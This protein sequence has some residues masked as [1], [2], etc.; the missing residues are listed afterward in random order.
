MPPAGSAGAEPLPPAGPHDPTLGPPPEASDPHATQ[1]TSSGGAPRP[2]VAAPST[3]AG[4]PRRFGDYELLAEVARGGMG[5]VYRARHLVTDRTVA[6]KMILAGDLATAADVERFRREAKAAAALEHPGIVP[7]YDVGEAEG[8]HYFTMPFVAGGSLQDRLAD[9]PLPP[10]L[11]ARLVR[12]LAEAVQYAHDKGIVHR[13][14]KPRNVLLQP[15]GTAPEGNSSA[16]TPRPGS[17]KSGHGGESGVAARLTDFGLARA[18]AGDG[19]TATGELLGTPAYMAPEQAA[20]DTRRIG[21]CSDVYGLG[22]VLYALLTG[23]PPFQAATP[24][25]TLRQVRDEEP[26]PPRRLNPAVPA[27]LATVCLKCLH[28]EPGRRYSSAAALADDLGRFVDGRPVLARPV[29]RLERGRRW[30]RRNPA[31]AGL[32][33]AVA[34]SLVGGAAAATAFAVRANA[35]A[36][37][38]D[39]E[40][41]E[42]RKARDGARRETAEARRQKEAAD[43]ATYVAQIGRAVADLE[44]GSTEGASAALDAT[45][46]DLRGWEYHLLRRRNVGTPLILRGHTDWVQTVAFSPDG[47][48]LATASVDDTARVWDARTGAELLTLREHTH[49]VAAVAFSPD[50]ARLATASY[51]KTARVWDARSGAE[52]FTLRGHTGPVTSL[53]FSSDGGRLAT[54]SEDNT[55]RVWDARIG[56]EALALRGHTGE[57]TAV[58]FSPD[59]RVVISRD[60]GGKRLAWEPATGK[61]APDPGTPLG[62]RSEAVSPDGRWNAFAIGNNVFLQPLKRPA[63]AF[64]PWA[65]DAARRKAMA[66]TWHAEDAAAAEKAGDAFAAAFH[67][68]RL[69]WLQ[70]FD[71]SLHDRRAAAL[72]RLGRPDDAGWHRAA[73]LVLRGLP[74]RW[75]PGV[76]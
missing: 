35:N 12:H 50:G 76:R 60:E 74:T 18:A 45:R 24:L 75:L 55:A 10:P 69:L 30:C 42:A 16:A 40:A 62:D 23:R 64:D 49:L 19:L 1:P 72:D 21:P 26:L 58:A 39:G 7:I 56:A 59:G 57:V 33:A 47:G 66:P 53:A 4:L 61:P 27:D 34:I 68:V 13:D 37:R 9:G 54:A 31:V 43:G 65:E 6:L 67:L 14:L 73:A 2:G 46:P 71:E 52:L 28:K 17:G 20:G 44:A 36:E 51:D 5:V 48:R 25:E 38:A 32:L 11:A 29:G 41:E 8:R 70:P 3:A 63:G 22:A 15:A